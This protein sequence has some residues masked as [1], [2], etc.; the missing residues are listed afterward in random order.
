[1]SQGVLPFQYEE[2]R[3]ETG[4]TAHAGL[5]VYLDMAHKLDLEGSVRRHVGAREGKQG[6][7]DYQMIL[8]LI[9]LNLA[10]GDCVDDLRI[11]AGD[12][13]FCRIMEKAA[14]HGMKRKERRELWRRWRKERKS[15]VP[16]AS[17]VFRY[18]SAFHDG[19]QEEL[20]KQA[21]A[22]K[23]FIPQANRYLRGLSRV[24]A[25]IAAFMQANRLQRVATMDMDA[26]LVETGK[27]D[28]FY[29]Y[30][31]YKSYQPLNTWWD[32]QGLVIHTEFR[33]GNVPAGYEQLRV[34]QEAL[35]CLPEGVEHIR[36][37]SD[38]AGYQHDLLA[39][40]DKGEHPCF[41]R[42]EFAVGCDVTREFKKEVSKVEEHTWKPLYKEIGGKMVDTGQEWAD[43]CFVPNAI[44]KSTTGLEYRYLALRELM[45][46]QLTLPGTQERTYPFPTMEMGEQK[47]KVFGTVSNL[48]WEGGEVIRWLHKRC[49]RSEEAHAIM[50]EDLAGGK[51]PSGDFGEN[52]AWWWIMMLSF[53]LHAAMKALAWGKRWA[54]KRMKAVRF[55]LINLPGRVLEHARRM[56][57][58][59]TG[60]H[61]SFRE[62]IEAR[63]RIARLV[64]A[65]SG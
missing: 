7:S 21:G 31:G 26:T 46:E 28:A 44:A 49:G 9:L 38:T 29:S 10:G 50:K 60:G 64:P 3:R 32:E 18:L 14:G 39:Y 36:L 34:F 15:S 54:H 30:K 55:A 43:V 47:Y 5:G 65:G 1:M 11:L 53:N 59:L 6:W 41:G 13:G 51:L 8:S 25:D 23:A 2:E 27:A 58:R 33:D 45:R 63:W 52:A 61:P 57:I 24:N 16:S 22:E 19:K 20:R 56:I 62:I 37:R 42:I 17:S 40:C 35:G 48:D 4:L 12:E